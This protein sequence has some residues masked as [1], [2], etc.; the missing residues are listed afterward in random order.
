MANLAI[1]FSGLTI[2]L[3]RMAD[4]IKFITYSLFCVCIKYVDSIC[5]EEL[6]VDECTLL[7]F[8]TQLF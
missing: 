7:K 5:I 4:I 1:F 8:T 3:L 6:K 2:F